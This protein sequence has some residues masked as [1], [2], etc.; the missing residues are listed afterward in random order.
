M[1]GKEITNITTNRM[2][3]VKQ[4]DQVSHC[5]EVKAKVLKENAYHKDHISNCSKFI[6]E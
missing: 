1:K 6:R 2:L 4:D 5:N 3:L